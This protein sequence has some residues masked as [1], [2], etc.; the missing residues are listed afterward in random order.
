MHILTGLLMFVF[1][2]IMFACKGDWSGIQAIGSFL[3]WLAIFAIIIF[4]L[5]NPAWLGFVIIVIF[6]IAIIVKK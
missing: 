6:I 4:F 1:F 5:M 3:L 2:S